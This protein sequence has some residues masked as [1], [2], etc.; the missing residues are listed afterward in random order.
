MRTHW[1]NTKKTKTT[2]TLMDYSQKMITFV[3]LKEINVT[4][5]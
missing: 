2:G 3:R 4:L 1:E 5:K